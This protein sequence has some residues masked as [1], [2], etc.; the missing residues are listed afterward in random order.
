AAAAYRCGARRVSI[1]VGWYV[2]FPVAYA[3][4]SESW[5]WSRRQR[6]LVDLAGVW[7]QGLVATLYVVLH[8]ASGD[9]V[10]LAAATA[11]SA[12]LAWNLNPLLRMD[13]YWLLADGLGV[14]NLRREAAS[15]LSSLWRSRAWPRSRPTWQWWMLTLYAGAAS[16]FMG[17]MMFW[18]VRHLWRVL[19]ALP[20]FWADRLSRLGHAMGPADTVVAVCGLL[21]QA[22][23]LFAAL[24]LLYLPARRFLKRRSVPTD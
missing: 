20:E 7:L 2:A 6:M 5:A 16:L 8:R 17:V 11:V 21:V 13:G 19:P 9:G 14:P 15:A 4:L 22:L 10:F 12:S 23:L 3:D 24:R 1:G 18:A